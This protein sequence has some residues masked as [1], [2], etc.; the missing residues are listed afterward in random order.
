MSFAYP[1]R[2]HTYIYCIPLRAFC[3]AKFEVFG[4]F[5]NIYKIYAKIEKC[6]KQEKNREKQRTN[7]II[8]EKYLK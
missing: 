1:P 4:E 7:D 8:C 2:K 5:K 3:Q 6:R